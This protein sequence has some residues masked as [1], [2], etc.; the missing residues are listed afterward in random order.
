MG[1]NKK[2]Y[3]WKARQQPSG[4]VDYDQYKGLNSVVQFADGDTD[5]GK[6]L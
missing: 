1:K 6:L 4:E 5:K 3:N 2:G